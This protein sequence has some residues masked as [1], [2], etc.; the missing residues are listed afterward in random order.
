MGKRIATFALMISLA[1]SLAIAQPVEVAAD[2]PTTSC[3]CPCANDTK[4]SKQ[5][6]KD[7]NKD[8]PA[9]SDQEEQFN[10]VL[11]GIYG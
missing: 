6:K 9:P 8:K 7:K 3:S 10:R 11:Q 2:H 5:N 1:S 4:D